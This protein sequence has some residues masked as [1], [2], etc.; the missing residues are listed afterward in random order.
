MDEGT[1]G[2]PHRSRATL[3]AL[4]CLGLRWTL[5]MPCRPT[6]CHALP[7]YDR[8]NRSPTEPHGSPKDCL[9]TEN[10]P[11]WTD[12]QDAWS[13][14]SKSLC[15][16]GPVCVSQEQ[17]RSEGPSGSLTGLQAALTRFLPGTHV[18]CSKIMKSRK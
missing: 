18:T 11:I 1:Q 15:T 8:E 13:K 10:V 14:K 16:A 4:L 6:M 7:L 12:V 5:P 3:P 17:K 2:H 9:L